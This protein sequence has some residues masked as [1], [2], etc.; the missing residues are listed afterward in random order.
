MKILLQ[1]L[2]RLE[3]HYKKIFDTYDEI[4]LLDLAH[5]L[6][7]WCDLQNQL[8]EIAPL[9][10]RSIAFKTQ[11]SNKVLNRVINGIPHILVLLAD[12][13]RTHASNDPFVSR[14]GLHGLDPFTVIVRAKWGSTTFTFFQF[15]FIAKQLNKLEEDELERALKC[16][17]L[18]KCTL[19]SWLN[20]EAARWAYCDQSGA[21][22]TFRLSREQMIRRVANTLGGSHPE[23]QANQLE[24]DDDRAVHYLLHYKFGGLPLPYFILLKIAQDILSIVPKFA[25]PNS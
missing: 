7:I 13:A 25:S 6:R 10:N 3:R 11:E 15:A 16:L 9:L 23:K 14:H 2:A 17:T 12:G 4:S 22:K 5:S 24:H 21:L 19:K 8:G 18:K 20:A 1:N